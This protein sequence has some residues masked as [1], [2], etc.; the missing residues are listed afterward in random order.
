MR[1]GASGRSLSR[2]AGHREETKAAVLASG[3]VLRRYDVATGTMAV[4][5]GL[6]D[7]T[8]ST[9]SRPLSRGECLRVAEKRTPFNRLTPVPSISAS[10]FPN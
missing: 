10:I 5:Q 1:R 4:A 6:F 3:H 8:I 9:T 7:F 2:S